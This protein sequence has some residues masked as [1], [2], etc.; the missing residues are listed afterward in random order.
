MVGVY[1]LLLW[2][3]CAVRFR[4]KRNEAKMKPKKFLLRS[5]KYS[6]SLVSLRSEKLE[7][8]RQTKANKEEKAM[9]NEK[10]PKKC[11][12][13]CRMRSMAFRNTLE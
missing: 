10:K 12:T 9:Q 3:G 5:E 7:I 8:A 4:L 1:K 11:E 2:L 13:K 6:F